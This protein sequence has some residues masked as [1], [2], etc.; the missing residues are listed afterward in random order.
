[1]RRKAGRLVLVVVGALLSAGLI[2]FAFYRPEIADGTLRLTPRFSI[3]RW[4]AALPTHMPWVLPFMGLTATLPLLRAL[5]WKRTIPEPV[6][7]L[8]ARFHALALGGLVH[9]AAPGRLGA[10]ATAWVLGKQAGTPVSTALTSLLLSK[11]FEFGALF[12]ISAVLA[13]L[14]R[15]RGVAGGPAKAV[16]VA[17]TVAFVAFGIAIAGARRF[18]PRL[19]ARW[20][21]RGRWPRLSATLDGLVAGLIAVRS[22]GRIVGGGALA[23]LPV[24][25][26]SMAYALALRHMGVDAYLLGGGVLVS[27]ITLGQFTPGLPIGTGVYYFICTSTARA[28]GAGA[29][30][31]AA[32]AVLSH[33]ATAVT[34]LLVG[35]ASAAAHHEGLRDLLNIRAA[36]GRATTTPPPTPSPRSAG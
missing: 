25:A 28:L 27:A 30:D 31:A 8:R 5:V 10:F 3:G 22:A 21:R 36:L 2:A 20:R 14:A 33:A 15:S 19:T 35:I 1:M 26:A 34:H 12:T 7:S 4:V 32:L 29:D 17:G 18:A 11:L 9:N 23:I 24:I 6:P 16:L 13:L